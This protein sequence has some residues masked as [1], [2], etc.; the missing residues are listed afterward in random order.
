[1]GSVLVLGGTGKTGTEV[2]KAISSKSDVQVRIASRRPVPASRANVLAVRFDWDDEATWSA[3]IEDA[4]AVYLV[5]PKT[6]DP[7][8][9]VAAFL[10]HCRDVDR[11]VLLS[12]IAADK[13]DATADELRVEKVVEDS[14]CSWTVL[15][16]NWFMQ[17]FATP[18][19]FGDAIRNQRAVTI[20]TAGQPLSFVDTRDIAAVA[21]AALIEEG[22]A[23]KHY[24]LT[25]PQALTFSEALGRIA[26]VAGYAASHVDPPLDDFLAKSEVGGA[27]K[28]AISYYRRIY[29]N[30]ANG[31]DSVVTS[32]VETVTGQ[33]ARSFSDF[34]S[35]HRTSWSTN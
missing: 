19:F 13:Q 22:H 21:T 14:P 2:A 4:N 15:R 8:R 16:P 10:T 32:D 7:A 29:S 26:T 20:P 35:E 23:K 1:M 24:T 12:E 30:I 9:T 34:V 27:S 33:K 31:F 28:S 11:L 6:S 3:A 5:K 17:N 18:S 25:G